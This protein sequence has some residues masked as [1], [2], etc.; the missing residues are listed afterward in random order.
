MSTMGQATLKPCGGLQS[1]NT[2]V[3]PERT[4]NGGSVSVGRVARRDVGYM[5]VGRLIREHANSASKGCFAC[6]EDIPGESNARGKGPEI[7]VQDM[8]IWGQPD[9][10]CCN[11]GVRG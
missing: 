6:S 11:L 5:E 9:A 7:M 1:W 10:A 4:S 8:I 3:P 2:G